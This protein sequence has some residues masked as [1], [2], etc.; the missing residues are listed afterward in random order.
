MLRA[1]TEGDDAMGKLADWVRSTLLRRPGPTEKEESEA[2][3]AENRRYAEGYYDDG[4]VTAEFHNSPRKPFS[5]EDLETD[6]WSA[7]DQPIPAHAHLDL[8]KQARAGVDHCLAQLS[9]PVEGPID[10]SSYDQERIRARIQQVKG[11]GEELDREILP[12][13]EGLRELRE[14]WKESQRNE[15]NQDTSRGRG[16]RGR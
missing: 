10:N 12:R 15:Q 5:M 8:L 13:E 9:D 16:G 3:E 7:I 2:Y 14:R 1:G 11:R 4:R 6:P